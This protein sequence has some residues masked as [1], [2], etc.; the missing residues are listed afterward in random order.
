[1][2]KKVHFTPKDFYRLRTHVSTNWIVITGATESSLHG[3]KVRIPLETA[4]PAT[5]TLG[6]LPNSLAAI[7]FPFQSL[8]A[9]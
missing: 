1:M 6:M 5:H 9:F 7:F 8:R 4:V 2:L 3:L